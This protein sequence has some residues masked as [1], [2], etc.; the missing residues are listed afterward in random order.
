MSREHLLLTTVFDSG[1]LQHECERTDME[2]KYLN[3]NKAQ[4]VDPKLTTIISEGCGGTNIQCNQA[5]ILQYYKS[6][7]KTLAQLETPLIQL[8]CTTIKNFMPSK[9]PCRQCL[10]LLLFVKGACFEWNAS[11]L[12]NLWWWRECALNQRPRLRK[13]SNVTCCVES[14][15]ALAQVFLVNSLKIAKSDSIGA[16]NF[17]QACHISG[18]W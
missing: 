13:T 16:K 10:P 1:H 5:C 12:S 18:E 9:I 2:R 17:L 8:L 11:T 7:S 4:C 14:R 3:S 6:K 15:F